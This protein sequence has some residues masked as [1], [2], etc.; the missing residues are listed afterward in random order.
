MIHT[1][2]TIIADMAA[3]AGSL[4]PVEAAA[5]LGALT[6]GVGGL[7]LIRVLERR[8]SATRRRPVILIPKRDI[9]TGTPMQELPDAA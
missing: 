3:A 9:F 8:R 5:A 1:V 2:E 7:A 4:S 6:L